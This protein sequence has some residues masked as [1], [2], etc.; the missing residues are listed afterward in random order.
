MS[1]DEFVMWVSNILDDG[2]IN[3]YDL[4]NLI[5]VVLGNDERSAFVDALEETIADMMSQSDTIH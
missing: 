2:I 3:G 5:S 4:A 1:D